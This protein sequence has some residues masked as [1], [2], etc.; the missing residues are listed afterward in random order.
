MQQ[1]FMR[2]RVLLA[3][4]LRKSA[5]LEDGMSILRDD[6]TRKDVIIH[7]LRQELKA[8]RQEM[9]LQNQQFEQQQQQLQ[10]QHQVQQLQQL[11]QLQELQ[12]LLQQQQLHRHLQVQLPQQQSPKDMESPMLASPEQVE[13]VEAA[14]VS[15]ESLLLQQP[16]SWEQ[17]RHV[18]AGEM[19]DEY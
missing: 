3:Q 9:E 17:G 1:Q 8:Q 6:L 11:Q 7:G 13:V 16:L 4:V 10:H 19:A 18:A 14:L 2:Q 12:R 5:Q 15:K